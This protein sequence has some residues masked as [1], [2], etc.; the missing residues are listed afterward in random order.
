[1]LQA[2]VWLAVPLGHR[3]QARCLL[4][5]VQHLLGPK[6]LASDCWLCSEGGSSQVLVPERPPL[7][8]VVRGVLALRQH[9]AVFDFP[10]KAGGGS[11][12]PAESTWHA[13]GTYAFAAAGRSGRLKWLKVAAS[14][15]ACLVSPKIRSGPIHA[16]HEPSWK[17]H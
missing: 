3:R 16:S 8:R 9:A 11:K 13:M 5:G 6:V 17:L 12:T 7:P 1:M 15:I 2:F 4:S 14:T 10:K